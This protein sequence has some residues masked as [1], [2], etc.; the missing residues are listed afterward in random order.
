MSVKTVLENINCTSGARWGHTQYSLGYNRDYLAQRTGT[1]ADDARLMQTAYDQLEI[2]FIWS[3][4]DGLI[5][6]AKAGR[7]TDMGHASYA[8]DGSDQHQSAES[9]FKSPGSMGL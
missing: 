8:A 4:N 3:I 6:W 5:D 9:P 7:V 1:P 2:D